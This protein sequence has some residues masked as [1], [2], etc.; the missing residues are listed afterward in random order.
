MSKQILS[1]SQ[2][3]SRAGIK[4]GSEVLQPVRVCREEGELYYRLSILDKSGKAYKL[5]LHAVTGAS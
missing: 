1:L 5:V 2:I 4:Y 3:K